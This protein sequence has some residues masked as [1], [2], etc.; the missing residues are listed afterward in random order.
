MNLTIRKIVGNSKSK[1]PEF[2]SSYTTKE[3]AYIH[4]LVRKL[5]LK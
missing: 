1:E 4:E 2:S 5:N 3:K